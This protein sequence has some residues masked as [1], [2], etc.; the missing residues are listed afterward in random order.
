MIAFLINCIDKDVNHQ[1]RLLSIEISSQ[2]NDK[3]RMMRMNVNQTNDQFGKACYKHINNQNDD[4]PSVDLDSMSAICEHVQWENVYENVLSG[5][6]GMI[7]YEIYDVLPYSQQFGVCSIL[8]RKHPPFSE[9]SHFRRYQQQNESGNLVLLVRMMNEH[10]NELRFY[11]QCEALVNE[12][13]RS[14]SNK[15]RVQNAYIKQVYSN[16]NATCAAYSIKVE[17]TLVI[18]IAQNIDDQLKATS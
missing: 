10:E 15:G 18:S 2:C 4:K 1:Q 16:E 8:K 14:K 17:N 7:Y 6:P 12:L 13:I 3:S 5:K 9:F 11:Q